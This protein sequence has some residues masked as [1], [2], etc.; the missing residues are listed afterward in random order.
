M[1]DNCPLTLLEVSGGKGSPF[2]GYGKPSAQLRRCRAV[3]RAQ[4]LVAFRNRQRAGQSRLGKG[5]K[6]LDFE[7]IYSHSP[8]SACHRKP[9]SIGAERN[10][11][12][13]A[14]GPDQGEELF[15]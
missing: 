10:P 7:E 1:S 8:V 4:I 2:R 3:R 13:A 11:P 15:S 14:T 9:A 5:Y 12:N 6:F